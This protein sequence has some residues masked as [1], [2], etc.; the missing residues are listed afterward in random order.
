MLYEPAHFRVAERAAALEVMRAHPLATLVSARDGEVDV[1]HA[2][3]VPRADGERLVLLGHVARANPHWHAWEH[4]AR[5]TAIFRGPDGYV[6]PSWYV[7]RAAVPTWNYMVVHARGRVAL[8]HDSAHKE[9]ILK[10]LIDA[11]DPAYR[12]QWDEELSADY[13]ERQK[14][15]IVGFEIEVESIAAKFKLSQNRPAADRAGVLAALERGGAAEEEMA[16]WL[17]RL[18]AQPT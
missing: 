18:T 9:K 10:A 8:T 11:H 7:V 12:R 13:R 17:R 2:P 14:A 5:V 16:R 6:S 15:H 4:A 1:T 3:L